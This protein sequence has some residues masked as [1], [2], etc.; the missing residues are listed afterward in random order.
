MENIHFDILEVDALHMLNMRWDCKYRCIV[1]HDIFL[2]YT[3]IEVVLGIP[4]ERLV[5]SGTHRPRLKSHCISF[6][7]SN[8]LL[9]ERM[10]WCIQR[11]VT[12]A[13]LGEKSAN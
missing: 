6:T 10:D 12:T 2:R 7:H 3:A 9:H 13:A 11:D 4:V 8:D 5:S 1:V